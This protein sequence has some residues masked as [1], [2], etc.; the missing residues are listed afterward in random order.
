M[1]AGDLLRQ[2]RLNDCILVERYWSDTIADSS[3]TDAPVSVMCPFEAAS[4]LPISSLQEIP[5]RFVMIP[6]TREP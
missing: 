2:G 3:E 1:V 6:H 4:R 5:H